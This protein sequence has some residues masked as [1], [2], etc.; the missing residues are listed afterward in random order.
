MVSVNNLIH[1]LPEERNRELVR[2][3]AAAL[4]PGGCLVIG[5]TA[6]AEPGEEW[7]EGGAMSSL[8]FY[9]WSHS[10]NFTRSEITAWLSDAGFGDVAV[11]LT[12]LA[13]WRI[14]VVARA[15]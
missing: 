3:A 15:D 5:D 6:G 13:P 7:A 12:P 14:L 4:R 11:H 10:R 2:M 8:L 9:A 1:H